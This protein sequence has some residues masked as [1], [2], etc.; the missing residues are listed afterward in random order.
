MGNMESL[1]GKKYRVFRNNASTMVMV[2]T[3]IKEEE[4]ILCSL[5]G[6]K[7]SSNIMSRE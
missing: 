2:I 5:V 7:A 4:A 6:A 3:N 1:E